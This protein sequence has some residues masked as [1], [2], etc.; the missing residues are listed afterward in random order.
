MDHKYWGLFKILRN[1]KNT[2]FQLDLP[3]DWN[4]HDVFHVSLLE[5]YRTTK[6]ATRPDVIP[7]ESENAVEQESYGD[8]EEY[9]DDFEID[10]IQDS[11]RINGKVL[12]LV[13]WNGYPEEKD[14]T[15]EP[16]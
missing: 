15:E 4:I 7:T 2:A 14:W 5:P 10:T 6:L 13:K 1:I 3:D 12:Y 16:V 9:S 8:A 11:H